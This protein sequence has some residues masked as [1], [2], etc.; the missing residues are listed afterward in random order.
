MPD[1]NASLYN[2][3]KIGAIL[4]EE[5]FVKEKKKKKRSSPHLFEFV[6]FG[7]VCYAGQADVDEAQQLQV[8]ELCCDTFD[9]S[10]AGATVIQNQLLDLEGKGGS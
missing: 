6:Q 7:D 3:I 2:S 9:L 5:Q 1:T 10:L 8:G 4:V